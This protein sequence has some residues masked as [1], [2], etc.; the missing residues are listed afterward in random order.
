MLAKLI[1]ATLIFGAVNTGTATTPEGEYVCVAGMFF[2]KY[3]AGMGPFL[4]ETF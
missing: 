4:V 3:R 1:I 2:Y